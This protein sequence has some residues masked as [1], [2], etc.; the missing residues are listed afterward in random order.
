MSNSCKVS[1]F[2]SNKQK[3]RDLLELLLPEEA[4]ACSGSSFPFEIT[5]CL[6]HKMADEEPAIF[7]QLVSIADFKK[8]QPK[9]FNSLWYG[10]EDHV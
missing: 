9:A 7:K 3:A 10:G 4:K 6:A 1:Y 8:D 5:N 2:E